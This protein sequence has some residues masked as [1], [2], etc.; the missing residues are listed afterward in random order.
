MKTFELEREK[1]K[2]SV[3]TVYE[4]N[5]NSRKKIWFKISVPY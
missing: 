3:E 5:Y 2:R 1:L 4:I